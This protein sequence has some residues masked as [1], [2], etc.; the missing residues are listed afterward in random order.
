M[1]ESASNRRLS[2]NL[3]QNCQCVNVRRSDCD[4]ITID[5]ITHLLLGASR[6]ITPDPNTLIV[7][8]VVCTHSTQSHQQTSHVTWSWNHKE[9]LDVNQSSEYTNR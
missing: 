8:Q 4:L 7:S 6:E 1:T 5:L 2:S 3:K 9:K